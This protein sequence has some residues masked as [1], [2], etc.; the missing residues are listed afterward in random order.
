MIIYLVTIL[1]LGYFPM[2]ENEDKG[3]ENSIEPGAETFQVEFTN[4]SESKIDTV[5]AS[6]T[7]K[8]SKRKLGN[9]YILK[10]IG[11]GGMGK[12]YQGY[13]PKN[14]KQVAIK[15]IS[16]GKTANETQ[17]ARFLQEAKATSLLEHPNIVKIYDID[18]HKKHPFIVMELIK[19]EHLD[20]YCKDLSFFEKIKVMIKV[21][22]AIH[23]AHSQKVVHRDL[24][25]Q[26]I[27][28]DNNNEPRI[29]DFGLAKIIG[30]GEGLT[31]TGDLVGTVLY[32]SPEQA[33]GEAKIIDARSDVFSLGAVLYKIVTGELPF[34][35][36]API[37]VIRQIVSCDPKKPSSIKKEIPKE[38]DKICLK[39]LAK[40]RKDRYQSAQVLAEDLQSLIL[41]SHN[42]VTGKKRK[43]FSGVYGFLTW[44]LFLFVIGMVAE[45]YLFYKR[46]E[47]LESQAKEKSEYLKS[48]TQE[49]NV[50]PSRNLGG[51]LQEL[52]KQIQTMQN[53][54]N[55]LQSQVNLLENNISS[56]EKSLDDRETQIQ[57]HF[58]QLNLTIESLNQKIF[59]V[60]NQLELKQN[61]IKEEIISWIT[62]LYN[63][64]QRSKELHPRKKPPKEERIKEEFSEN[65][66]LTLVFDKTKLAPG[67]STKFRIFANRNGTRIPVFITKAQSIVKHGH[68]EFS[69][70]TA[71]NFSCTDEVRVIYQNFTVS[72]KI[73]VE[74][75]AKI[76]TTEVNGLTFTFERFIREGNEL[77]LHLLVTSNK[78]DKNLR[79]FNRSNRYYH[80]SRF[81]DNF[82]KEH[83]P[84]EILLGRKKIS[85]DTVS[86]LLVKGIPIKLVLYFSEVSPST[87]Y[88]KLLELSGDLESHYDVDDNF[89]GKLR[90]IYLLSQK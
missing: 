67:D 64:N 86:N 41:T 76:Y 7:T 5:E 44:S 69:Q 45:H 12:I 29:M 82:G 31:K 77:I 75:P 36:Y 80:A 66:Q 27:I 34:N 33:E 1:I 70:Y 21:I 17:V 30:E 47:Y 55:E 14:D 79:L 63:K 74:G 53:K 35:G 28:V 78:E 88:L 65:T 68:V 72:Q 26:N 19:G 58:K 10:K 48:Q 81:I 61:L 42:Q 11:Q 87:K 40:K 25:P 43:L 37:N 16:A 4:N 8:K 62:Q 22:Q 73:V 54:R 3:G 60:E 84:Y 59:F 6:N 51:D 49:N 50:S 85:G 39:A 32:M 52:T 13:D 15:M 56:L 24:K 2:N 46:L 18:E 23:Y 38:F 9:Y 90:N 83:V 89:R 71:P 20:E 57:E